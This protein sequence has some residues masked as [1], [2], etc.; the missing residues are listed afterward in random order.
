[1]AYPKGHR[2]CTCGGNWLCRQGS[3]SLKFFSSFC[4]LIVSAAACCFPLHTHRRPNCTVSCSQPSIRVGHASE[5]DQH[6]SSSMHASAWHVAWYVAYR[7]A[8][9]QPFEGGDA[10]LEPVALEL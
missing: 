2:A 8:A 10:C 6:Q 9:S 5:L 3:M 4:P 7:I 1:M